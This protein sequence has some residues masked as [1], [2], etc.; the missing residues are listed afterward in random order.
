MSLRVGFDVTPLLGEPSGVYQFTRG[1]VDEA[2]A[3][4]D[5]DVTGWLLTRHR[6]TPDVAFAVRRSGIP[7]ALVQR[8]WARTRWPTPRL[9]A[10]EVDIIH[11]TNF[12]APPGSRTVL[13]VHDL[14]PLRAEHWVEPSVARMARSLRH[15]LRSGATIHVPSAA[16]GTEL[17]D[18]L[19]AKDT[20]IAVIPHGLSPLGPGDAQTGRAMAGRDRYVLALG[21]VEKRKNLE[22]LARAV[23]A[24]P[25]DVGVV[26]AGPIGNGD[27]A[28]AEAIATQRVNERVLRLATLD[29]VGRAA[30]IRG[31]TVLAF[32]SHHEG[33]GF[34]PLEALREGVSV[35]ATA[36]GA[37]P[38]L[39]GDVQTLHSPGDE[40]TFV[41]A[42][43]AAVDSPAVA[44]SLQQ[45]TTNFTWD[46]TAAAFAKLY[47]SVWEA[48]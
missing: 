23:H 1:L 28:L 22:V 27:R 14:T 38:E 36:V 25:R 37:L 15:T 5:L 18:E 21:T 42:L 11:G 8:T 3:H 40:S 29:S 16:V 12:L 34:P 32:P 43:R 9:I 13:T 10:G 6:R 2:H 44:P 7:A 24:L 35:V 33:F 41:D 30:L 4:S 31:A 17:A 26:I 46:R 47:R 48:R 39:I 20:T 45:R 19:T